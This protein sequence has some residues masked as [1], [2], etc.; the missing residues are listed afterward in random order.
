MLVKNSLEPRVINSSLILTSKRY[1][2]IATAFDRK[3]RI[4]GAGVNEYKRSHP[5]MKVYAEKAGE[6]SMK[7]F[8]HAE[9]SAVL[10]AGNKQIHSLLVQRFKANGEPALAL[11]CPTCQAMLKDFGVKVVKYTTDSGIAEYHVL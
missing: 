1:E 6:S 5:L 7:I 9:F 8:K 11:P 4:L 2:I 10:A 3:G